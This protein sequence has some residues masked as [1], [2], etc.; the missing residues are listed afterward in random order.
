MAAHPG[1]R[2]EYDVGENPLLYHIVD[3]VPV[4][5]LIEGSVMGWSAFSWVSL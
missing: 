2:P 4:F 3:M 1:Y 5:L